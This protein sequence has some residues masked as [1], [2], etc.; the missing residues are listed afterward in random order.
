MLPR[1]ILSVLMPFAII[2]QQNRVFQKALT[3]CMGTLLCLGG[4]TVCAALRALGM[5]TDRAYGRFHR[6]LNR[7]RWNMLLAS[8]LL[9]HQL[10]NTFAP[11]II[12]FA[13]D[14]TI[15]RRRGKKI[16]A[17]GFFKD[18][19]GTGASK[20]VTCS[21]LRWVPIMLLVKVPFMKRTI[22]LPFMTVLSPSE[23][24]CK[25]MNRR[26]KSPQRIAEQVCCLLRRWLPNRQ[27]ILV[28]DAGYTTKGLFRICQT[29]NIQLV[30]RARA[31]GRF[32]DLPPQRTGQR[33]RPKIKGERL[34]SLKAMKQNPHRQWTA[35][36]M[37]GYGGMQR[38]CWVSVTEC[39]WVP[40]EGGGVIRVR[41]V[42]VK[43]SHDKDDSPVFCL[44]TSASQ[45]S[46]GAIVSTYTCRWSQEVTH[47]DVRE[48]LGMETQRQWSDLSISR[49]TPLLFACYSLVFL[50]AHRMHQE[51]PIETT[52][53]SWYQ[54]EE[55][56]FSDLMTGI[57]KM[58]REHQLNRIWGKHPILQNIPC[59]KALFQIF[60]GLGMAA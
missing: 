38:M 33:G 52:Q 11:H 3:L 10:L 32:F 9:L 42:F 13:I 18:P 20:I 1:T 50:I 5:N 43:D 37:E 47:R 54:K 53:A 28:T 6:L 29:L 24:T 46:L 27:L 59:P 40:S 51:S 23:K 8:K 35:V 25:K 55:P 49:S 4:V 56:A 21:G 19:L 26:H 58:I 22:A 45:L 34:P 57:R 14:D 44:I 7:D 31:N 60:Q 15:E 2:F 30:A 12:T 36:E 48:H 17:K 39:C 16:K 41:L